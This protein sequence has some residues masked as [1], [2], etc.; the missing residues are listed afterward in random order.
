[1]INPIWHALFPPRENEKQLHDLLA[2]L[3]AFEGLTERELHSLVR[4]IHPRSYQ[5]GDII[6]DDGV[7]GA[8]LYVIKSGTVE[9]LAPTPVR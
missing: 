3:P 2:D 5:K 8:A 4:S 7:P 1:M 6:F 9:I